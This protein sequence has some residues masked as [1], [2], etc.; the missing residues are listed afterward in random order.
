MKWLGSALAVAFAIA[1][2][3]SLA[4]SASAQ[5]RDP[6]IVPDEGAAGGRFQI[7]GQTGWTPGDTVMLE[8]GFADEAPDSYGGP[9]YHGREITVL[10]DG[11][12]SF[13]IVINE[14]MFPFPLW[15][16]GY[17]VVRASSPGHVESNFFVYTV[18]GRRPAG[19]PPL[20]NLG[21]GP[22][23]ASAMPMLTAMMFVMGVGAMFVMSG[24]MR[25]RPAT[26]R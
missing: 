14:E 6:L 5:E 23:G 10:R 9:W 25:R 26:R 1:C 24:A 20:A 16:P 22:S 8:F 3:L 11:T 7:V 4:T 21:F 12:W 15:R 17:I 18:D 13:P 19:S 2:A